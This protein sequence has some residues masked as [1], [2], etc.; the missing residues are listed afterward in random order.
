MII[1]L[2]AL[3]ALVIEK[4]KRTGGEAAGVDGGT[5][6]TL[7]WRSE[8]QLT[9]Q[10]KTG[11]LVAGSEMRELRRAQCAAGLC[12]SPQV[13]PRQPL[14]HSVIGFAEG[15]AAT[16]GERRR[17]DGIVGA[18]D[19]FKV[20][21]SQTVDQP[22]TTQVGQAGRGGRCGD[23]LVIA[24]TLVGQSAGG[25]SGNTRRA[26]LGFKQVLSVSRAGN[27]ARGN[28]GRCDAK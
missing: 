19:H 14:E 11:Q 10:N 17:D 13:H 4:V 21:T 2:I 8:L 12:I 18:A 23:N 27:E 1:A 9:S 6:G 20:I 26:Y 16:E 25:V 7:G 28:H 15:Y 22:Q 3:I 24:V 5:V